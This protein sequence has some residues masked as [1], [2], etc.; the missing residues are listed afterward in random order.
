M[1]PD[2][3]PNPEQQAAPAKATAEL[4]SLP[5][6]V[7]ITIVCFYLVLSAGTN[8]LRDTVLAKLGGWALSRLSSLIS[9]PIVGH[10]VVPPSL[11]SVLLHLYLFFFRQSSWREAAITLRRFLSR[12]DADDNFSVN[13][14][15]QASE[16]VLY[17]FLSVVFRN[18]AAIFRCVVSIWFPLS[19][20]VFL[21]F[22]TIDAPI[23][24]FREHA[25]KIWE[26]AW[27]R[28]SSGLK[29]LAHVLRVMTHYSLRLF[30]KI[31]SS[32]VSYRDRRTAARVAT[33]SAYRYGALAPGEIRLLKL[34][35]STPWSPVRCE[36]TP[37]V[38]DEAPPFET[39]SYTWGVQSGTKLLILDNKQF[40]VSE[41][42]YDIVHDRASCLMTRHIWIDSVCI[43]Q[44]DEEEKS[45]QVQLMRNIYGSSYQTVIW[46]GYAPD[47]NDAIGL[48]AHIARRIELDDAVERRSRP[49]NQLTV[50][51]PDWPALTG[52]IKNDYWSRCW[53]IQEIAVPKKV[54]ISYGG[55]LI[56]W[57]YFSFMIRTMFSG[58]FNSIWHISKIYPHDL[59]L[60][61][62]PMHAGLQIV[63]LSDVRERV[64]ANE[65]MELFDLLTSSI[66]ST[67]TDPRDNIYAVQGISTAAGFG[68]DPGDVTL[69]P[70]YTAAIEHPFRTVAEHTLR[71]NRGL[72]MFHYTGIGFGRSHQL[73]NTPSW[74]P[75]WSTRRV[76]RPYWR[77]S[78]MTPYRASS[79]LDPA[80]TITLAL[81]SSTLILSGVIIVDHITETGPRFF[82]VS[83]N[84]VMK[85][86]RFPGPLKD[87]ARCIDMAMNGKLLKEPYVT[88]IP[89]VEA[90]W[91]TLTCDRRPEDS[92]RPADSSFYQHYR[93]CEKLTSAYIRALGPDMDSSLLSDPK[94]LE[95][96][97]AAEL[98]RALAQYSISAGRFSNASASYT[99][100][101]MFA[102]TKKGYMGLVPPFSEKGDAV[103]II[104]GAQ[105]PFLLR[106]RGGDGKRWQ[107]VGESYF[108][109]MMDGEMV[110]G[111][112]G[113]TIELC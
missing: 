94:F 109:G 113:E 34:S 3:R 47:A 52:L 69:K 13:F 29:A 57:D 31:S 16:A 9:L 107:L 103:C 54:I 83:E 68:L 81:D 67:A 73:R 1:P 23:Q 99:R 70:D 24:T 100:E 97:K 10:Y 41:R 80:N 86:E 32:A 36:L 76:S 77:D 38:L 8:A 7:R 6:I 22:V 72:H 78:S 110:K 35:K 59:K 87:Y 93:A 14:V 66:N 102:V 20:V 27:P 17:V 95:T 21:W 85:K 91:R 79:G 19:H 44:R 43:N 46:L 15:V 98:V 82:G 26:L 42:V 84:G 18:I 2:R 96:A 108:Y 49:L 53:V 45:S 56:T 64:A 105:V 58:D 62:F 65:S 51:S 39:I 106:A 74:V 37:V 48:L 55:E 33:L 11:V 90:F 25:A 111:G 88:G 104:P 50:E 30:S 60:E 4:M 12:D 5:A 112:V 40:V 71:Q 63:M 75:D 61:H 89:L 28:V 101:R 92:A